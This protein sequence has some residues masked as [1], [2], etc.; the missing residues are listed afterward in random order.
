MDEVVSR[1]QAPTRRMASAR[2][3]TTVRRSGTG[4]GAGGGDVPPISG[5]RWGGVALVV[6]ALLGAIVLAV[7][8]PSGATESDP[9]LPATSG[10]QASAAP[11]ASPREGPI[12][13]GHPEITAPQQGAVIGEW[14]ADVTVAVPDEALPRRSLSLVILRQGS[15]AKR[16]ARPQLGASVTVPDVPLLEGENILSAALEGP[17]GLGPVSE[18]VT[19][20]QDRD[21]PV[22]GITAPDD[23]TETIGTTVDLSGTSEAGASVTI[24]NAAKG[25][26]NTLRVGPSGTFEISVPLALGRNRIIIHSTDGAGMEQRTMV[27]VLRKDGR[28]VIKLGAPKRVARGDLPRQ[29]RVVVDVT[30][31]D[32]REIEGATVSYSLGGPGWTSE[33]WVDETNASGRS[34]WEVQLVAGASESDPILGVEVIAPNRERSEVFQ[35]IEIS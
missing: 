5:A 33:D 23:G 18:P 2:T 31:T 12:P 9:S 27:V 22:L 21:A 1:A 14:Y 17:G 13:T 28:P 6:A 24:E 25:W 7:V 3:V 26:D 15:E 29:I 35:E 34:T 8:S 10:S 20:T 4:R 11:D 16:L 19:I 32:G 30:D